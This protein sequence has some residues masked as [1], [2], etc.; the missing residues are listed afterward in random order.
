[1][2]DGCPGLIRAVEEVFPGVELQRCTKHRMENVLEK[3][4]KVDR[5]EDKDN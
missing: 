3:V 5:D 2:I 4:L 1:M